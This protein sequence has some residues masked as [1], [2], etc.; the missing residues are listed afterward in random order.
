M[1]VA[2][3]Q[4]RFS[5]PI[6]SARLAALDNPSVLTRFFAR[7]TPATFSYSAYNLDDHGDML[8]TDGSNY[9]GPGWDVAKPEHLSDK[10]AKIL[11]AFVNAM[12]KKG[13]RV[14]FTNTP[15]IAS[16]G[17]SA[18]L[19]RGELSFRSD[20]ARVGLIIERREDMVFERKYFFNSLL[21]LNAEGRLLRTDMLIKSVRGILSSGT[22]PMA[23][24]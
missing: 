9:S 19:R 23:G 24:Q 17:D 10:S 16:D 7:A 14:C 20:M 5:S 1:V 22:I 12:K 11:V 4:R 21:H 6:V 2:E 13:V 18:D 3:I 15:Y 8:R